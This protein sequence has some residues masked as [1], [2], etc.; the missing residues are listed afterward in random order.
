MNNN[1]VENQILCFARNFFLIKSFYCIN[2]YIIIF[3]SYCYEKNLPAIFKNHKMKQ[4]QFPKWKVD[5]Y[6]ILGFFCDFG[7]FKQIFCKNRYQQN[8]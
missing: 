6:L 1:N 2:Y 8:Y 5:F 3:D 4:Y 7:C